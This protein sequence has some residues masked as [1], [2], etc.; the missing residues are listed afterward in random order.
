MEDGAF[1]ENYL[2]DIM[3]RQT[4]YKLRGRTLTTRKGKVTTRVLDK[5]GTFRY[6][7]IKAWA[8]KPYKFS[9]K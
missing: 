6:N 9:R 1:L 2:G 8:F 5:K 7:G 4:K 3:P